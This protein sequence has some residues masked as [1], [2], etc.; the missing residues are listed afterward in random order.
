MIIAI[1]GIDGTGKGTQSKMLEEYLTEKRFNAKIV[2]FPIYSSFFG[3]MVSEYLNGAYGS[4]YSINPKLASLLYAQDRQYY[5]QTKTVSPDEI[6]I[7]DRYVNS[8]I[9][10]HASKLDEKDRKI[11]ID[12]I[13][14][15]EYNVNKIPRP[16]VS[17]I[18]DLQVENSIKNVARKKKREYTESTHDLH[19][20]NVEYLAETRK[21]FLS[22]ANQPNTHLIECD[23]NGVLR[24]QDDIAK[25]INSYVD[26]LLQN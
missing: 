18:L 17:F 9:A 8:N 11:L 15:L 21:V 7:L 2:S 16:D 20:S 19:E 22:L 13:I 23:I 14:E 5:F 24:N 1:D 3:K 10:H 12:W 4:L 26:L 6:I 25:E